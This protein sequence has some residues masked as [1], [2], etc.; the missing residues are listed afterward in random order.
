MP[1]N[2][3]KN[4]MTII[5]FII[6]RVYYRLLN[7]WFKI[8]LGHNLGSRKHAQEKATSDYTSLIRNPSG[9]TK[10]FSSETLEKKNILA[11]KL[12]HTCMAPAPKTSWHVLVLK[13]FRISTTR[14]TTSKDSAGRRWFMSMY[15]DS[16]F[17][18]IKPLKGTRKENKQRQD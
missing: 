10:L 3:N 12:F 8:F 4:F 7:I 5:E 2:S 13:N 15:S 16:I 6:Y 17:S 11:T 14:W 1:Y 9:L 18:N